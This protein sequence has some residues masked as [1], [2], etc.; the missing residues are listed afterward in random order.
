V[1]QSRTIGVGVC[2]V[3]SVGVGKGTRVLGPP[4]LSLLEIDSLSRSR[5]RMSEKQVA[6]GSS[7]S[8][9]NRRSNPTANTS[10]GASKKQSSG[11]LASSAV[12][13]NREVDPF[14]RPLV[15]NYCC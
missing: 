7:S 12:P 10:G 2:W 9:N 4:H 1:G 3:I 5:C 13:T 11:N 15:R 8:S 14:D 6:A